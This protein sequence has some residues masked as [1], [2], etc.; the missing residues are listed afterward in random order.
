VRSDGRTLASGELP[1]LQTA[2]GAS[3][4]LQVPL[5]APLV[6]P[7][8]EAWIELS[9]RLNH[10][11]LW[12]E[13]GHE[14]A[15]A[16][17]ALPVSVPAPAPI[18]AAQLPAMVVRQ[19]G[20]G[21]SIAGPAFSVSFNRESGRMASYCAAG[22][23][24]LAA[25][26]AANLWRAPTDNDDNTWGA[27]KMAMHWR[28]AGLDRLK[29]ELVHFETQ[30]LSPQVVAV[31]VQTCLKPEPY[32]EKKKSIRWKETGEQITQLLSRYYDIPGIIRLADGLGFDF[33]QQVGLGKLRM[34]RSLVEQAGDALRVPDLLK[35]L[36]AVVSVTEHSELTS[37]QRQSILELLKP[38]NRDERRRIR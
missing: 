25:G 22:R 13:A 38:S 26:P 24:L 3:D 1:A 4:E 28:E 9:F 36:Y 17:F 27:Q 32:S 20:T 8:S 6:K 37:E 14:V 18:A 10:S 12:A 21:L 15:W 34:A 19:E 35:E 33:N 29:E 31:T 11:E 30:V 2:P 5:Q 16:Q 23:E 7:G